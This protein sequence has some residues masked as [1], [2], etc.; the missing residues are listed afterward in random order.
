MKKSIAPGQYSV[1]VYAEARKPI[2]EPVEVKLTLHQPGMGVQV[3]GHASDSSLSGNEVLQFDVP[4]LVVMEGAELVAVASSPRA[5]VTIVET[6]V[7]T[8]DALSR[9]EVVE[10]DLDI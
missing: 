6:E 4:A 7:D 5:R 9:F 3:L 1:L 8:E 2:R 10:F